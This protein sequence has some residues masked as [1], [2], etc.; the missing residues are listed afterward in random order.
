[1]KMILKNVP[2]DL[3]CVERPYRDIAEKAGM[4]EDE[5]I[6]F[7]GQLKAT[8]VIRRIAAILHHRKARYSHNAMVVW[9]VDSGRVE[10]AG[11]EMAAFPE[12]SH[13][14]ER[15]CGGYWDYNLY[16][17]IHGRSM[18]DCNDIVRRMSEKT[19][20]T[21]FRIF[22]STREFKKTALV[23]IDE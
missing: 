8:G 15:E 9:K 23:V 5:L 22:L 2:A 3:P 20:L 17:M 19:G 7:L 4:S 16:T 13:C 18:D 14:Y 21:D 6:G 12:V 10:E 1:M 11:T